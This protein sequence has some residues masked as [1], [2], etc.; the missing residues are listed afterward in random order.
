[1]IKILVVTYLPWR[2]DISVGNTLSNIFNGMENQI[3]FANIYFRDDFPNNKLVNRI[4]HISEKKLLKSILSR[5]PVGNEVSLKKEIELKED[6][7]N[8]YNKARRLRWDSLL[9]IQDL[10]GILG[11]WKSQNLDN[12]IR[13]FDPDI[14]FG[15][16]GRV[17]VSN[18]LMT[19]ISQKFNIP[20]ICYPW[21]DHY[22]LNKKSYSPFFWIKIFI[23]RNAI[24]KC[25][26]QSRFLYTITTLMQS[27]YS[28]Y[29]QKRCK[30][31]YK[32][33]HFDR[34]PLLRSVGT[35]V[36]L[37]YMGN[38]GSG[39]WKV[40]AR[41]A[42]IINA[43]NSD[44]KKFELNIYTLSPISKGMENSLNI[45]SSHLMKPVKEKDKMETLNKADILIHA[46]P[47]SK[48]ESQFF[49]LSFSTKLV[50]YF[51]NAK[52][53]LAIG[54]ETA[55]TK[56]LKETDSAI[57]ENNLDIIKDKLLSILDDPSIIEN[58]AEKAWICGMRNH[59]ILKIQTDLYND[60]MLELNKK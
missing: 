52:C 42:N 44:S 17:P 35:P 37:T 55:S 5:K 59:N 47:I 46:E 3:E 21:D 25:A 43:I 39:R 26:K 11:V 12:F 33:Y 36:I 32:G 4:F 34:K 30:V 2:D 28:E 53:I 48:K 38:I 19:Y 15:P 1:M 49:R 13:G 10:I 40:L 56:Y 8:S 23:E 29:F 18:N 31:L 50:D 7:S 20:L 57:V 60:F 51:Y 14:I 54:G 24:R 45:G 27:E 41:L 9:L 6:F 58:Y 16:L 22:S